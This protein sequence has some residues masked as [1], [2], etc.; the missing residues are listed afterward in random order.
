MKKKK[1]DIV[2]LLGGESTQLFAEIGRYF[3]ADGSFSEDEFRRSLRASLTSIRNN[4]DDDAS[5]RN[6]ADVWLSTKLREIIDHLH[7]RGMPEASIR[8][9]KTAVEECSRVGLPKVSLPT[10]FLNEILCSIPHHKLDKERKDTPNEKKTRIMDAALTVFSQDGYHRATVDAVAHLAG[11]A[12]GSVYRHF[13]SKEDLLKSLLTVSSSEMLDYVNH[14][15]SIDMELEE[16]IRVVIKA[17]VE[18]IANNPDLYRLIQ[19]NIQLENTNTRDIFFN[20]LFTRLPLLKERVLSLNRK[21]RIRITNLTFDTIFLGSYGFVDWV[22]YK[23]LRFGKTY[24]LRD[25][26]PVITEMLLHGCIGGTS[27]AGATEEKI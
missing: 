22:F 26:V 17:W 11:V 23:W 14:I 5:F 24:D 7:D 2:E 15:L 13:K 21:N 3:S 25:E 12:K 27:S 6:H 20:H 1:E 4:T 10:D 9:F 18:F 16:Q 8:L 19:S